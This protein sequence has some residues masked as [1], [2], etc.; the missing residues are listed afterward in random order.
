[1]T[2]AEAAKTINSTG[3]RTPQGRLFQQATVSMLLR[4]RYGGRSAA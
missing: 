4:G 1:L 3:H 2:Q